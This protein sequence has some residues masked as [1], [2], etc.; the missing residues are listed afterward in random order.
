MRARTPLHLR[1][2]RAGRI[3]GAVGPVL[4]LAA[5]SL[6]LSCAHAQPPAAK[7]QPAPAK[8]VPPP[9]LPPL[10]LLPAAQA[11]RVLV[12]TLAIPKLEKTLASGVGLVKEATPLPLDAA[13]VR[14]MLLSQAGLPPEVA[15]HLDLTAPL[16]GASVVGPPGRG[17]LNAFSFAVRSAADA[18]PLLAGL[19][20]TVAQRGTAVQIENAA[21]DRGWFLPQ[22]AV[23]LFADSEDALVAAGNLAAEARR[24]GVDD[25]V[26]TIYPEMM[27]RA[28]ETDLT[29]A[30]SRALAQIEAE[31]AAGGRKLSPEAA[32]QLRQM[33]EFLID[34]ETADFVVNLD[35]AR[36]ATLLARLHP[37]AGTRLEAVARQN[38]AVTIDAAALA[39]V[40]AAKDGAG[41]VIASEYGTAL[42]DQLRRLRGRLPAPSGGKAVAAAARVLDAYIEGA[43]GA[44]WMVARALPSLS[45]EMVMP[46]RDAAAVARIQSALAASDKAARTVLWKATLEGYDIQLKVDKVQPT[47]I[48]KARGIV[49]TL[50]VPAAAKDPMSLV[51]R[52]LLGKGGLEVITVVSADQR[53]IAAAGPGARARV[54]AI[55]AGPG[56]PPTKVA[57][58]AGPA[59]GG[60]GAQ[61]SAGKAAAALVAALGNVAGRS[62]FFLV[63]LRQALAIAGNVAGDPRLAMLSAATAGASIPLVGGMTGDGQGRALTVDLT[64]PPSAFAGIGGLVQAA[65]M[66]PR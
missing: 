22:G 63:D 10:T 19:G 24:S 3:P 39:A 11:R 35:S 25:L 44:T 59:K 45:G 57:A 2:T 20:R 28:A 51:V 16:A 36:G 9:P 37:R 26:V 1:S 8:V 65:S 50:T 47:A 29:S 27:A 38:K 54:A 49:E 33:A 30:V 7:P 34:T 42:L 14:D 60:D 41:V 43:T 32:F 58:K 4:L 66:L 21:G 61:A 46:A 5:A 15:K 31:S 62:F 64:L 52:K 6:L 53:V 23:V 40:G 48:G 18:A 56:A 55:A 12:A 17:P 13:G